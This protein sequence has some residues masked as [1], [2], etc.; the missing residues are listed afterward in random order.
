MTVASRTSSFSFKGDNL[1]I[2]AIAK[3]LKVEYILEGSVRKAGNRI[4]VTAQLID[5]SKDRHL[6]SETFDRDLDDIFAIQDQIAKSIAE[7]LR[8][9]LGTNSPSRRS[10]TINVGAYDF[11]LL[12]H[13]HWNQRNPESLQKA[14]EIFNQAIAIV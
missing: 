9:T 12:G 1:D 10:G 4:R 5:V 6:W 8:V 13:H 11:Y 7:A 3:T 2:P 14:I